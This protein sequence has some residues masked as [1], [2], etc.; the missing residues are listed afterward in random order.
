MCRKHLY[1]VWT[2]LLLGA[3]AVGQGAELAHRWSFNGDL[4]DS[5][6]GQDAVIV[7]D[8]NNDAT[9]SVT[10]VTMAGGTKGAS[11]YID[12]ADNIVSN[13]GDTVTFEC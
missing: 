9:L 3:A 12:L 1:L 11:D 13:L 4:V 6:G 5:V 2:L 10:Q 8:G 7:D